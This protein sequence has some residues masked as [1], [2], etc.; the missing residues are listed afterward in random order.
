MDPIV[1]PLPSKARTHART[2]Q[3]ARHAR[4]QGEHVPT[5]AR[6]A[7][8][9]VLVVPLLQGRAAQDLDGDAAAEEEDP[10]DDG[11]L[12]ERLPVDEADVFD[13]AAAHA[14]DFG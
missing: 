5:N 13:G 7:L 9:A 4:T 6:T 3:N 12:A 11:H 1:G 10:S 14:P 8:L 2:H